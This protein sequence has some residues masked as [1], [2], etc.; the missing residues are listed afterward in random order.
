MNDPTEAIRKEL[1]AEL[2]E[3]EATKAEL[4]KT[5][6]RVW[7]TDEMRAEF[8]PLGF[9]APFIV[10]RKL[11]TGERGSLMFTHAPRFYFGWQPE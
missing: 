7:S 4:E 9:M 8:E 3:T 5:H 6:G 11:D 10:V 1:V 2:N